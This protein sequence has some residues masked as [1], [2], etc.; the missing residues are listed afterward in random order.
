MGAACAS[1]Y[2]FKE[3][4]A[5]AVGE[6]ETAE[7][8]VTVP[9]KP[10]EFADADGVTY[11]TAFDDP[12]EASDDVAVLSLRG[13]Y[14][15]AEVDVTGE[16]LDGQGLIEHDAYFEPLRVPFRP[17][18]DN[19]LSITCRSPQDRF[20]GLHD[21]DAVPDTSGVPGVWWDATLEGRTLPYIDSMRVRPE[22][23]DD[24]AVLH[25][26]TT[27]VTDEQ[28]DE[29]VTYSLKPAG[30]LSTRGMMDRG[31]IDA[32]GPGKTTAE[33]TI[34]IRDPAL[35]WPRGL[36]DQNRYTLR[37]KLGDSER[38]VTT[39]IADVE[40]EGDRFVVNGE[41][42]P[43]RG[44]GLD[45]AEP[46]DIQRAVET[47]AN[48]VRARGHVLPPAVYE[49][50]NEAGMLVWQDL[51]LTG[52]GE[53]DTDRGADLARRLADT[54]GHHPSLAAFSVHDE[55]TAAFAD[56]LG[57][58]LLDSLRLRWRAWRADYDRESADEVAKAIPDTWPVFPVVGGP[59]ID[60]DAAAYYPGWDYGEAAD[61]DS[62]LARYP[63]EILGAFGAGSVG[64]EVETTANFDADT[65]AAHLAGGVE[66]SQSYQREV[67]ET[68]AETARRDGVGAVAATLR[69]TDSAGKGVYAVD[70]TPKTAQEALA[71]VF[72]PV[73]VF[74][75]GDEAVVVNGTASPAAVTLS[76]EAGEETG[77]EELTVGEAGR[78]HTPLDLPDEASEVVLTLA[79]RGSTIRNRYDR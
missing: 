16:R 39:G 66:A 56:G 69:D 2:M 63:T 43:I 62:L 53:F 21:T 46:A 6:G 33:H 55:P 74:L 18:E 45:T 50:A 77:E 68:V 26:R 34:E 5:T 24:G 9:G 73:Q 23:T 60:H 7:R 52:P 54:Y 67:L 70:G 17:F 1:D 30:D 27:V 29:R 76:W 32:S 44:V 72:E 28:M 10:G 20:G 51:P 11:V 49:A 19:E 36:G 15:H 61:I 78:S 22:V 8:E 3:W 13:L 42:V 59:G 25:V 75:D 14:A 38:T 57:S 37:A 41:P 48:L 79:V 64:K 31:A 47:N 65:H 40:R 4:R 71:S 12:R 35:W 58:G